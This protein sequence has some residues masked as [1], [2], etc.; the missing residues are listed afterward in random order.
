MKKINESVLLSTGNATS[1]MVF[2]ELAY[3][4]EKQRGMLDT[5]F[6]SIGRIGLYKMMK[7]FASNPIYTEKK[8][9][10][11]GMSERFYNNGPLKALYKTLAFLSSKPTK[12]DESDQRVQDINSVLSKIERMINGKLTNEEKELFTSL[13]DTIDNYS[14][15][16]NSNLDGSI[17]GSIGAEEPE[18]KPKEEPKPEEK[19]KEEP[20][21]E[22]KPKEEPKPEE[23]PKE[24]PKP[25]EKP[26][27]KSIDKPKTEEQFRSI[28][29]R[30]VKETLRG[31]EK[32]FGKL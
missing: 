29:K 10:M 1:L 25:E 26:K 7:G 27:E 20:K 17:Q 24:E 23:K 18:E 32:K 13:E 6:P 4:V 28:I 8:D 15:K 19:P 22:E 16:L 11:F 12:E 21:P 14:D 30:L 9:Q 2:V 31:Y 3:M 5:A